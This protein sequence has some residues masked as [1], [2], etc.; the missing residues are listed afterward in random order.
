MND[1]EIRSKILPFLKNKNCKLVQEF[2]IC[3]GINIA[4]IA[5]I[6]KDE[7]IGYEIKS[8]VDTFERFPLQK[9]SYE[10][11]F[12]KNYLIV[13]EKYSNID[14]PN[15]WG[16]IVVTKNKIEIKQ[17]PK[18]NINVSSMSL[19]ELLWKNELKL[20]LK[21]KNIKG[22]SNANRRVLRTV[23]NSNFNIKEIKEYVLETLLSRE[24][25]K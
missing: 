20:L 3:D 2:F 1:K 13:G 11:T 22:Y 17:L 19:L 12:D 10:K 6:S 14:I 21:R 7:I 25:W 4:D 18:I 16:F 23:I 24:D 8:D 5:L 15:G 9:E